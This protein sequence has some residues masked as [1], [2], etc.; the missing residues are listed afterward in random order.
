MSEQLAIDGLD[1]LI[2]DFIHANPAAAILFTDADCRVGDA[3]EPKLAELLEDQFPEVRFT[4]VHRTDLPRR[5][6]ELGV[7]TFPT[8]ITWFGGRESSRFVRVFSLAAVAE[9]IERP[10]SILFGH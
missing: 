9:A 8:L 7:V 10:Y 1:L 2:D 6:A 3:V 5:L 4:V